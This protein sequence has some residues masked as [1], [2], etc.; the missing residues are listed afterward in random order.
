MVDRA[1]YQAVWLRVL[2]AIAAVC[3]LAY[4]LVLPLALAYLAIGSR[5]CLDGQ[6]STNETVILVG[7]GVALLSAVTGF[8]LLVIFAFRPRAGLL[9][10]GVILAVVCVLG[11]IAQMWG[12]SGFSDKEVLADDAFQL[13]Y[14]ID[15]AMQETVVSVT[16]KS[17][18]DSPGILG[19]DPAAYACTTSQGQAGYQS[20]STLTFTD[21]GARA[22]IEQAWVD[23]PNLRFFIPESIKLVQTWSTQADGSSDW[24]VTSACQPFASP[25]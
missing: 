3:L 17:L 2:I 18:M 23:Q 24:T 8:V 5:P 12:L 25:S 14:A 1:W 16:G 21:A 13:S 7:A 15:R 9:I 10:A 6:C 20:A 19:P 11:T 4:G 22:A